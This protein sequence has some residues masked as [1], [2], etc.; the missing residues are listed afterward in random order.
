MPGIVDYATESVQHSPVLCRMDMH[1][2]ALTHT[3]AHTQ[4]HTRN[5]THTHTHVTV[6]QRIFRPLA[7]VHSSG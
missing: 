3:D 7:K 6:F 2:F 4:M 1:T 5:H